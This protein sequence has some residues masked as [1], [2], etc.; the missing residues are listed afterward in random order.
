MVDHNCSNDGVQLEIICK[1][2]EDLVAVDFFADFVD[3]HTA[4]AVAVKGDAEA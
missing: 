3:E 2:G 4:V 1:D